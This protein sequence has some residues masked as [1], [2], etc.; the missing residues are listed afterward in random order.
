LHEVVKKGTYIP[1]G[2][3]TS[4]LRSS[5]PNLVAILTSRRVALDWDLS[6]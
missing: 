6:L 5:S 3:R 2:N 4:I 1:A